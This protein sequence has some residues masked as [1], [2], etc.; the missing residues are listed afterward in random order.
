MKFID[1]HTHVLP[2]VDDGAKDYT[3][4]VAMLREAR[5]GG[6]RGLVATPHFRYKDDWLS[7][8]ASAQEVF[9]QLTKEAQDQGLDLALQLGFEVELDSGLL[10]ISDFSPLT[11]GGRGAYLLLELPSHQVPPCFEEV[12][13]QVMVK[14][15]VPIIA[16]PERSIA[17]CQRPPLLYRLVEQGVLLQVNS[18]SLLGVFGEEVQ[19]RTWSL[20]E[21]RLVH[22]IASDM[23]HAK[24][25]RG[26][27]LPQV[28]RVLEE[29]LPGDYCTMLLSTHPAAAME[30]VQIRI[31]DPL[32]GF[33]EKPGWW[34]RFWRR[35]PMGRR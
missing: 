3:E 4:A 5:V 7:F 14:G 6:I 12:V 18:G 13:F 28:Q 23:H 34:Q 31:P 8:V 29:H 11:I 20:L 27:N 32:P 9:Q 2:G 15:V 26:S 17:L 10:T 25:H 24:G 16:H 35:F 22:F 33:G 1:L 30:G 19:L 21:A